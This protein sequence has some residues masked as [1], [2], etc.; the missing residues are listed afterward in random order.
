[1]WEGSDPITQNGHFQ[2]I[3]WLEIPATNLS[4]RHTH[5]S[6]L[7]GEAFPNVGLC[8][9]AVHLIH[10]RLETAHELL[11]RLLLLLPLIPS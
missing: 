11:R 1:M 2:H 10:V 7:G 5:P 4:S 8:Q 6:L 9:L 3:S